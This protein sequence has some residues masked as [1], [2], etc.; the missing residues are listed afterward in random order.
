L[1]QAEELLEAAGWDFRDGDNVRSKIIDGRKVPFDFTLIT[2]NVPERVRI[3]N[4][5]AQNLNR[6]GIKCVVR[7]L[8]RVTHTDMMQRKEFDATFGGWGT[9]AEPDL[10][11]NIWATKAINGGRNWISYSNR[12]VDGLY[13]LAKQV[14]SATEAREEIVKKYE[15]DKIGISPSA[16]RAE[17]YGKIDDLLY[18]DQPYTFLFYRSAFYGFNKELRGYMFSPRGPYHYSPGFFSIW[19]ALQ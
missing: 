1:D 14:E 5:L 16:T 4:L 6:I 3:C 9:G 15:L 7:P 12:Y 19:N 13:L 8:E 10:S 2:T 11:E 17:A 18:A